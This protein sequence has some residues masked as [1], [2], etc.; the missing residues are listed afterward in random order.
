MFRLILFLLG[1]IPLCCYSQETD[2]KFAAVDSFAR[3]VKYKKD[4]IGLT[5]ELTQPYPDQLQKARAIFRWITE[6][7]AYDY[8]F[9]NKYA[10]KE[11]GPKAYKCKGDVDCEAKRIVWEIKYID[12]VLKKNKAVCQGYSMLFKKMCDIVG[13]RSEII[14]GYVRTE[15][16]QV[17]SAGSANHSWNVIYLDSAY[18]LLDPTWA[19]GACTK[20]E[21]GKLLSYTKEFDEYYWMTPPTDFA[22]NHFPIT[23]KWTLIPNYTKEKF[24]T[25]PYYHPGEIKNIQLITPALGIIEAK[26]GDTIQFKIAY[27]QPIKYLQINSNQFRNPDVFN[28]ETISKRKKTLQ[29]DTLALKRQ[30]Y[31]PFQKTGDVYE[32]TYAVTDPSLYYIDILVD[33]TRIMRFKVVIKTN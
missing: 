13:I 33:Y 30:Q 17:G 19:A 4:L 14:P 20:N 29:L 12:K 31:I 11:T 16:Y 6:N 8:K 7:I 32:F 5:N 26:K 27:T 2:N 3:T 1:F 21:E 15:Y 18:Y 28:E 9:V 24:T 10:D 22:R 23:G 25:N